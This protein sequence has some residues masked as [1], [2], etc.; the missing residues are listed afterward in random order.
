MDISRYCASTF[1]FIER[2][3]M[4][5]C[6]AS[7]FF[8][9]NVHQLYAGTRTVTKQ[10]MVPESSRR[11]FAIAKIHVT[12]N[13]IVSLGSIIADI[14]SYV[15][16]RRKP[17]E[18]PSRCKCDIIAGFEGQDQECR[19]DQISF[20]SQTRLNDLSYPSSSSCW[21]TEFVR[22]KP[23]YIALQWAWLI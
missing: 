2:L 6:I 19:K 4:R 8:I 9:G 17:V 7:F 3:R 20:S 18:D 23:A 14:H 15:T 22:L 21:T 10:V 16:S 13:A 5:Y 1:T 11:N 12:M